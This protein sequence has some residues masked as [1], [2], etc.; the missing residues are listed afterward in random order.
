MKLSSY[1]TVVLASLA[2]A[3]P[4]KRA[5]EEDVVVD[6]YVDFVKLKARTVEVFQSFA[7]LVMR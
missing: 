4:V 7:T 2:L 3:A 5:T 6:C 1:L